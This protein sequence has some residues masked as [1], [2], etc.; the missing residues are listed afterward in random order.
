M[1]AH[2]SVNDVLAQL[3]TLNDQPVQVEG[4][5][6][7]QSEGFELLHYPKAE[8]QFGPVEGE[9]QYQPS[10]WLGFG[11]GSLQPNTEALERWVGKRV[12]I[13]GVINS[14]L[15]L[16]PFGSLGRGGFGPWG[17]W[18]AQIEPYS[19]QRVTAEERRENAV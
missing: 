7:L 19:V 6:R 18:P 17:F 4:I 8:R 3:A 16:P 15:A 10:I 14:Y 5:L 11:N 1:T 9:H 12:R 2:R 13:Y